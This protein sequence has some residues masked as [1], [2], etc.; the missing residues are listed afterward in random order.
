[1]RPLVEPCL[2]APRTPL[3]R[4]VAAVALACL[5]ASAVHAAV[6]PTGTVSTRLAGSFAG[7]LGDFLLPG[8]EMWVGLNTAGTLAV[9]GG[10]LLRVGALELAQ[11][12]GGVVPVTGVSIVTLSGVGSKIE[13]DGSTSGNRL[14]IA[15]W[16]TAVMTVSGGATFDGR[17]N[18]AICA[19]V[20]CGNSIAG[21]AGSD[22]T[23]TVT[24]AGSSVSLLKNFNVAGAQVNNP[25]LDGYAYG[26]P[27]GR[28]RATLNV[29]AGATL[30][31]E[32]STQL[33][34]GSS[35]RGA[36]GSETT[37]ATVLV[38][39]ANSVWHITPSSVDTAA[40][41]LQTATKAGASANITVSHGG[42][43]WLDGKA[44]VY[45]AF[46]LSTAGGNTT[47]AVSG[48]GST[49]LFTG[50][51]GVLQVGRN[52]AASSSALS[53]SDGAVG[54][55]IF[56]VSVGRDGATGTLA[57]DGLT[58]QLRLNSTASATANGTLAN[59]A[60]DIGRG[61]GK[62]T[63]QVTSGGLINIVSQAAG[64]GSAQI[65]L[66]RDAGS[67]GTLKI[68]GSG[69][70][71]MLS[72]PSFVAGGGPGEGFNPLVRVGR[73]A[74]GTGTLNITNGGQ[75][76][77]DGQAVSTVADSRSTSLYIGG[78]SDT[79]NGGTGTALVSG[80]GSRIVITGSDAYIGV[81]HGPQSVGTLTLADHASV[82]TT[83]I[84][85]GRSGGNGVLNMD[86]ARIELSGQQTGNVLAG[87]NMS[88]G[89]S[90]GTGT[91]NI[92]NASVLTIT[93][94]GSAGASFNVGG[95]SIGPLGTGTVTLSDASL[96]N[97]VAGPRLATVTVGRDGTGTMAVTG[98]SS[99]DVGDGSVTIARL[100]GSTGSMTLTGNS[101][102]NAGFVGV[103]RARSG[104]SDVD[105][106][107]AALFINNSTVMATNL[108][109]GSG[110][111]LGGS[112][113]TIIGNVTNH[114]TINAGNSPGT[115]TLDGDFTAAAGS[116]VVLDVDGDFEAG[117]ATDQ[118]LFGSSS[119]QSLAG[120]AVVF[121]FLGNTS[122]NSFLASGRFGIDTFLRQLQPGGG[123]SALGPA[124]YAG[125][126]FSASSDAYAISNFS[127]IAGGV[128]SFT[129]AA[130]PE[131]G[132]GLLWLAGLAAVAGLVQRRQ[133]RQ[134]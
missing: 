10:S 13:L 6:T 42:T 107:T 78:A 81:A 70:T 32:G 11:N 40:A 122:P 63:A 30:A 127:Y 79:A 86:H 124:A 19:T 119:T 105:G 41:G 45:N 84:S 33:S 53:F 55:G 56:Y 47:M 28:S 110:G 133:R 118:L 43:L 58:T 102:V 38:D 95:T 35:G 23:L 77:I 83:I 134:R 100:V 7:G 22:G 44:G 5:A 112:G 75:L 46:G 73:D 101:T 128:A 66:G 98:A 18:S 4:S 61:G 123:S 17:L 121:H 25:V 82:S 125:V 111:L 67:S 106:G 87:A 94:L 64:G 131:P 20:Y 24:G 39:G 80:E 89:R 93:N 60:M 3:R 71:V 74:G 115:L 88:V 85:V 91:A 104:S 52:G 54:T 29:L 92:G 14:G 62:G 27:G 21:T 51:A 15:G 96:L 65:S 68:D 16:G 109:I 117:F 49:L 31:T 72:S 108:V 129:A 130:V 8:D 116:V 12:G 69:S 2:R 48:V 120:M 26:T 76:L 132:A 90:G 37:Q 99:L 113:G 36:N 126:A 57:V 103:G 114:G 34:T 59:A 50:D 1:M 9:N 97:V